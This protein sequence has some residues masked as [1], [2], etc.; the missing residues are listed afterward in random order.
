MHC[1]L[2]ASSNLSQPLQTELLVIGTNLILSENPAHFVSW[3]L[4]ARGRHPKTL[5][6]FSK[7]PTA[8]SVG[9]CLYCIQSRSLLRVT[10]LSA[11]L[12]NEYI[13]DPGQ[14]QLL[15]GMLEKSASM[16][17]WHYRGRVGRGCGQAA[18]GRVHLLVIYFIGKYSRLFGPLM[19]RGEALSN[20]QELF[21]FT[22]VGE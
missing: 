15:L 9:V 5:L 3:L 17:R 1:F 20:T 12:V 4:E 2:P 21:Y 18:S 13:G 6:L 8:V 22:V 16:A 10:S 19:S 7:S 11:L 14:P